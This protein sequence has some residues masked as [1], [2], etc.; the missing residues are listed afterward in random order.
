MPVPQPLR[1]AVR[2]PQATPS[3]DQRQRAVRTRQSC[4]AA[5][6]LPARQAAGVHHR[7]RDAW[8]HSPE[9]AHRIGPARPL[10]WAQSAPSV[11]TPWICQRTTSW[12]R[13]ALLTFWPCRALLILSSQPA[14]RNCFF[15]R[16]AQASSRPRTEPA[17]ARKSSPGTAR[18]ALASGAYCRS[19][20][21]RVRVCSMRQFFILRRSISVQDSPG[22]GTPHS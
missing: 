3:I 22:R 9:R 10:V 4:P 6:D 21:L 18:D 13:L 20:F 2:S 14:C 16:T 11:R 15:R 19:S 5:G 8:V 12:R 7:H 17:R 1:E